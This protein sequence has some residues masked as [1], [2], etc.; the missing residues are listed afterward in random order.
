MRGRD[1]DRWRRLSG[2]QRRAAR[3]GAQGP[4]A[5][6][7]DELLGFRDGWKG[8]IENRADAARR[9][10]H[11]R[12]AARAAARSS[13]RRAPTPTRSTAASTA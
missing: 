9:R 6:Y 10:A 11:A 12:H 5:H 3:R 4:D 1:A 8:V 13:A 2:T 7:D